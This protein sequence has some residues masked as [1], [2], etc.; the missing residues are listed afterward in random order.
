MRVVAKI[1]TASDTDDRGHV[2]LNAFSLG[3]AWA[4]LPE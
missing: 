4:T 3:M 1:G 2:S